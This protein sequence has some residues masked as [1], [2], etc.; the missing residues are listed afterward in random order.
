MW[1][2]RETRESVGLSLHPTSLSLSSSGRPSVPCM[3]NRLIISTSRIVFVEE[4]SKIFLNTFA[5]YQPRSH[6]N[7]SYCPIPSTIPAD[8]GK[9]RFSQKV[10]ML[11][12]TI[13]THSP[14][15]RPLPKTTGCGSDSHHHRILFL[16]PN[17][18]HLPSAFLTS[19][20]AGPTAPTPPAPIRSNSPAQEYPRRWAPAKTSCPKTKCSPRPRRRSP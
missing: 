18:T 7:A 13:K 8:T 6:P 4:L 5:K 14:P 10:K 2:K 9:N 20:D 15:R 11:R 19:G 17:V 1:K 12:W 16:Y 3:Q